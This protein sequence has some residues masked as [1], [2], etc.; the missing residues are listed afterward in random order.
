MPYVTYIIKDTVV[1]DYRSTFEE[2]FLQAMGQDLD[3]QPYSKGFFK[4]R[5]Y[6]TDSPYD[7]ST[8]RLNSGHTD[9]RVQH[10]GTQFSIC[11]HTRTM[12]I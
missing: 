3:H 8:Y 12:C 5:T 9:R 2:L 6:H 1:T 10:T 11:I 4:T 7:Q